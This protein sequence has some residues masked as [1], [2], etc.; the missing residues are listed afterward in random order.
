[1]GGVGC[2]F[3]RG[4][5]GDVSAP[6][7]PIWADETSGMRVY[8]NGGYI[9]IGLVDD[10]ARVTPDEAAPLP[11]AFAQAIAEASLWCARWDVDTRSYR[12]VAS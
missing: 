6:P 12:E 3:G 9:E 10:F 8:V 2:W 1:M 4:N 5:E 7:N 11:A